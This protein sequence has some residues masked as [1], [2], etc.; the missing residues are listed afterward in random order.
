M[1]KKLL[2]VDASRLEGKNTHILGSKMYSQ[3]SNPPRASVLL[4]GLNGLR[5]RTIPPQ[6]AGPRPLSRPSA[7]NANTRRT[8]DFSLNPIYPNEYVNRQQD[9]L[10]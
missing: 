4:N 5:R 6:N 3:Y 10:C 1:H 8:E 7:R 2:D 9:D